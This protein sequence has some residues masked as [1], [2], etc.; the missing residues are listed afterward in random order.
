MND[1]YKI[2]GI[3]GPSKKTEIKKAYREKM[4]KIHPDI[5]QDCKANEEAIKINEAYKILI[6][7]QETQWKYKKSNSEQRDNSK[8]KSKK[9]Y[10]NQAE[11]FNVEE[12]FRNIDALCDKIIKTIKGYY[13]NRGLSIKRNKSDNL[14]KF[15]RSNIRELINI[16][17][18]KCVE[19]IRK[20]YK[21]KIKL[22]FEK[23][24]QIQ[25]HDERM[26]MKI[27][28]KETE[29]DFRIEVIKMTWK[30]VERYGKITR[31]L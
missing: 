18:I 11:I 26:A 3:T 25:I 27:K 5:N 13:I 16:I 8:Y 20:R 7:E 2:L 21:I 22:Q 4:F 19:G 9:Y 17:A 10:Q 1:Y 23:F 31:S 28:I 29:Y 12:S 14:T 24:D 6:A 15:L 30:F